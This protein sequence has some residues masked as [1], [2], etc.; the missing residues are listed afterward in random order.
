M[1]VYTRLEVSE[2]AE[3]LAPLRLGQLAAAHG[4]ETG[5]EN[6]TYFLT[7]ISETNAT[8]R[9]FVLTIAETVSRADLEFISVLTSRLNSDGAP[10]PQPMASNGDDRVIS[11]AGKA[12]LVVPKAHGKHPD[13]PTLAQ[14]HAVGRALAQCHL[15]MQQAGFSHK[16][17]RDLEWVDATG[18]QLIDLLDHS[19]RV[20]L[21]REL[22]R[23]VA[24]TES[25]P[26]L[27]RAIIH[28]D[29]FR[30]NALFVG[31]ELTAII[32][33]F[34]AGTGYLMFDL[35]VTTN[36]WCLSHC[37]LDQTER[38]RSLIAGYESIRA[39]T[40]L[41]RHLWP[42]ILAIAALRFW[43]SRLADRLLSSDR[44]AA[45]RF[46]KDPNV[47]RTLLVTHRRTPIGWPC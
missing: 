30:D 10:V 23:L 39:P 29:L 20:L 14:C 32:D 7:F 26:Q 31:D 37:A 25:H 27:P 46:D 22:S 9:E 17:H 43:V 33:F 38:L 44:S 2:I 28:G 41:E 35:A 6:T 1:A 34:S 19:N 36:D 47:Y 8:P 3:A 18:K 16:G 15:S 4:V 40:P 21:D 42:E 12:A 11:I 24:F 13:Q 5:I 45:H